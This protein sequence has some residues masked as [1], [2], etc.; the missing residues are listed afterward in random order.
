M[1]DQGQ[2][3]MDQITTVSSKIPEMYLT[4][5]VDGTE[6]RRAT[7]TDEIDGLLREAQE[8]SLGPSAVWVY[9]RNSVSATRRG[10]P[11][12]PSHDGT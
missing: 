6:L 8:N 12:E 9:C 5:N 4:P 7:L 3:A 2:N 11:P 10:I 1:K